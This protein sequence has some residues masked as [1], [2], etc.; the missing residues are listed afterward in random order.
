MPNLY[1]VIENFKTGFCYLDPNTNQRNSRWYEFWMKSYL[2]EKCTLTLLTQ[3]LE[4]VARST[5]QRLESLAQARGA[6][7]FLTTQQDFKNI[8]AYAIKQAQIKRFKNGEL[9]TDAKA[10]T[11]GSCYSSRTIVPKNAGYF[12]QTIIQGLDAVAKVY[13]ELRL[14]MASMIATINEAK[15]SSVLVFEAS[16][17]GQG[18]Y[19][20]FSDREMTTMKS[21]YHLGSEREKY[22]EN[23]IASLNF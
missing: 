1:A 15:S 21:N 19:K 16:A 11:D 14:L 18:R 22:A 7:D 8:I 12:E 13:P 17:R 5:N 9:I 3:E 6:D 23:N 4:E 20:L 10:L 2:K